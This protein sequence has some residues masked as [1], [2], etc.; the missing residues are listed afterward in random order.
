VIEDPQ[1][2]QAH[3]KQARVFS[4]RRFLQLATLGAVGFSG[5]SAA[6]SEGHAF[7]LSRHK[8]AL[9]G[10]EK[11][12]RLVQL[13]DLHFGFWHGP[14][15]VRGWVDATLKLEPDLIVLTGDLVDRLPSLEGLE[16]LAS[17]LQR[18]QA[19]LGVFAV[20]GNHDYWHGFREVTTNDLVLKLEQVGL[21]FLNNVGVKL[22]SDFFLAGIDD[23][24]LGSPKLELA[25]THLLTRGA[26]VLLSHNP[27]VLPQVPSRVGLTLSG[28]TH[29]GQIRAPFGMGLY[30]ISRYGERFQQGFV[31]GDLGAR[32][33][34]SRGLGTGG[35]PLRT[36]CPA[37]LVLLELN[38]A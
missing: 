8:V 34:V 11:P 23:L 36:F 35:L 13:T 25:L 31:R 29:G 22:R 19:P 26:S 9:P 15:H 37:E 33:F 5:V 18:L 32:G 14:E 24:L 1:I 2:Q 30:S 38:P 10:L 16:R 4:R 21:K 17:E 7:G 28:H 3:Q 20:L 6:W 27:D 12:L